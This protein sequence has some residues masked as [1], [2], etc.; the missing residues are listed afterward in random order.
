MER[1]RDTRTRDGCR[2]AVVDAD[3]QADQCR[4]SL[5]GFN[6]AG[7]HHDTGT[8]PGPAPGTGCDLATAAA[9]SGGSRAVG[10]QE[11]AETPGCAGSACARSTSRVDPGSCARSLKRLIL[12]A[13]PIICAYSD[14]KTAI[15]PEINRSDRFS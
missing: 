2:A 3:G 1:A 12:C 14:R 5:R 8:G 10:G 4:F 13:I 9:T 6:T 7:Q 15:H 11:A